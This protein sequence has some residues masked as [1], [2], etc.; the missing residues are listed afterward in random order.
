ML[1]INLST[2]GF[3]IFTERH[4]ISGP[5]NELKQNYNEE[6]YTSETF[7]IYL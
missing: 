5:L 1:N 4:K 6:E 7:K 3:L 2:F